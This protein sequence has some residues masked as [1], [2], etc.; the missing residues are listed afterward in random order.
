[1]TNVNN[2]KIVI[3]TQEDRRLEVA[4]E[5]AKTVNNLTDML[6]NMDISISNIHIDACHIQTAQGET[7]VYIGNNVKNSLFTNNVLR[8]DNQNNGFNIKYNGDE[9]EDGYED[10]DEEEVEVGM[11]EVKRPAE[12]GERIKVT[13]HHD[14][15]WGG[16]TYPVGSVWTVIKKYP[17]NSEKPEDFSKGMVECEGNDRLIFASSYVVLE[18]QEG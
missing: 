5:L 3:Q 16:S 17:T 6:K 11:K 7:A 18:E 1:M 12:V 10:E 14:G 9:E 13:V 8:T 15:G 4:L 2:G